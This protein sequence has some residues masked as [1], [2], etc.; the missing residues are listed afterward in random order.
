MQLL[1]LQVHVLA[2]LRDPGEGG[3]TRALAQRGLRFGI[4]IGH[5]ERDHFVVHGAGGGACGV[6]PGTKRL[7]FLVGGECLQL[8]AQVRIAL[9][10]L[11]DLGQCL[12]VEFLA[13]DH[14][15][16][17]QRHQDVGVGVEHAVAD[18][19]LLDVD[20]DDVVELLAGTRHG[21]QPCRHQQAGE[22]DQ[23]AES[24]TET[25]ADVV[26]LQERIHG[27]PL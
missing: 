21:Q 23:Q 1:V 12:L 25:A 15:Q 5:G 6:D 3:R 22:Q 24:A 4:A 7:A 18:P 10:L 14:G 17:A 27:G 19:G 16:G 20:F 11:L 2:D 26:A 8:L 9:A 13:G